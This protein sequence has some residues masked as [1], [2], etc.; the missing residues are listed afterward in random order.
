MVYTPTNTVPQPVITSTTTTSTPTSVPVPLQSACATG[1]VESNSV[2]DTC[3]M[4]SSERLTWSDA[5]QFC[6]KASGQLV[7]FRTTSER[8]KD[9]IMTQ[10]YYRYIDIISMDRIMIPV[11]EWSASSECVISGTN[12]CISFLP[13]K[14]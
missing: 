11:K 6:Q 3:Y 13:S 1:W 4:F 14:T 2:P 12:A 5:D 9:V 7:E 10:R 8:V